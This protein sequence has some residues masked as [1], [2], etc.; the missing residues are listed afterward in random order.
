MSEKYIVWMC[1]DPRI[2]GDNYGEVYEK[3][4]M[5]DTESKCMEF[6][7]QYKI[8]QKWAGRGATY[9]SYPVKLKEDSTLKVGY[10]RV[11][12]AGRNH[13]SHQEQWE[14]NHGY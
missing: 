2:V 11:I 1:H 5:I 7:R 8:N 14:I 10:K 9:Y 3:V 6:Y 12:H 4:Y 13:I